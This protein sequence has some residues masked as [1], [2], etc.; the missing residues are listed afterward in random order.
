MKPRLILVSLGLAMLAMLSLGLQAQEQPKASTQEKDDIITSEQVLQAQFAS[1]TDALLKL[2]QR[3]ARGTPEERK[4]AEVLEKVLEECDRLAVKQDFTNMLLLMREAKFNNTG[5][6]AKLAE[7][8]NTIGDKLRKILDM[9]Q[10][11]SSPLNDDVATLKKFIKDLDDAITAQKIAEAVTNRGKTDPK[12]LERIQ[13][14]VTDKTEKLKEEIDKFVKGKD[15][16]GG[17]AAPSKGENKD[18]G[19]GEGAKGEAKNDGKNKPSE[20]A[21]GSPKGAGSDA[22][23][24]KGEAKPSDK[25]AGQPSKSG[26]QEPKAGA[27]GGDSKG[28]EGSPAAGAKGDQGDKKDQGAA[29]ENKGGDKGD[30]NKEGGAKDDGKKAGDPMKGDSPQGSAKGDDKKG[31]DSPKTPPQ[32][33]PDSQ[34]KGGG[35][36][37]GGGGPPPNIAENKN[38]K[39][40]DKGGEGKSGGEAKG[41]DGKQGE[42]KSGDSKSGQGQAKDG[43][44][45]PSPGNPSPSSPP[46]SAKGDNAPPPPPGGDKKPPKDADN[47]A[48]SAKKLHEAGYDQKAAEDKIAKAQTPDALK[49]QAD[50][51]AKMEEA[52]KKLE[53]LLRQMREEEIERVLAALQARCEKM[54]MMQQ[55]V[56]VATI[57]IEAAVNKLPNK[58][59]D[60]PNVIAA[61]GQSDKE[62]EIVQECNKCVAI[63]E[64]EGTAV[65]FPE[66]FQQLRSDMMHVQKRLDLADVHDVTQGIE[67][68]IID[69][70]KE[71]IEALKKA[72]DDNQQDPGKDKDGKPGKSGKPADPKLL[73]LIQELKMVR[74]LQKRVNDRTELYGKRFPGEQAA[75]PQVVRELRSLADRQ[76]RIQDIVS[77]I[78]KGD[79][80]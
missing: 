42:S 51:I 30:K 59:A 62:K 15:G 29:K 38:S 68:D 34:A 36:P 75:D 8:S 32:G 28:K 80:K 60:R 44:A 70:L 56:L 69:S 4:R 78:A 12:D 79:N 49:K 50:A 55:Q 65:A 21:K 26:D 2:K 6:V 48:N 71:M 9:L 14:N 31:G 74:A 25:N 45:A 13:K 7:Q 53:N 27:K 24:P 54:L 73:E 11:S 64:G 19:K 16:K 76:Q 57:D 39:G 35:D 47:I 37:K 18:G 63:L 33:A 41:G 66:V 5:Q 22:K 3:L 23:D 40:G 10:N 77:R 58:K 17:E 67:R 61:Q 72:R 1:F 46:S 20:G 43:G 52:K